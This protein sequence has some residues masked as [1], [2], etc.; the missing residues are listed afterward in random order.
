MYRLFYWI[1]RLRGWSFVGG[2]PDVPRFVLI[3]GPHTSNW[4]FLVLLAAIHHLR[5]KPLFVGKKSLFW[6]PLSWF[7]RSLGGIPVDR[8]SPEGFV[9][10]VTERLA[11]LE[12][13]M[14]VLAPEET[15]SFTEQWKSGFYRV[16]LRLGVP[17]VCGV[18]D[19]KEKVVTLHEPFYPSEDR[20][21][22]MDY[23]RT[24]FGG[25]VGKFP[26]KVGPVRL[27]REE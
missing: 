19:F 7:L 20:K 18:V 2:A 14:L 16:A 27:S 10:E 3:G 17:V 22:D 25:G 9:D 26:E 5:V 1:H 24:C 6:P 21:S 12:S 11:A 4:D 8:G 13:G 15:R 23:V